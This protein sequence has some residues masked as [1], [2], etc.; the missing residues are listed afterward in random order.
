MV[1]LLAVYVSWVGWILAMSKQ[2][3]LTFAPGEILSV[4]AEAAEEGVW[5]ISGSTPTGVLLYLVWIVEALL[6]IGATAGVAMAIVSS[7]VFCEPCDRW[8]DTFETSPPL[9]V[10][11]SADVVGAL[12]NGDCQPVLDLSKADVSA[13]QFWHIE[14]TGCSTCDTSDLLSIKAVEKTF[15][16]KGK[17]QVNAKMVVEHLRIPRAVCEKIRQ[18][19]MT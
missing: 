10:P 16:K 9:A 7:A 8:L 13:R 19:H 4:I 14:L 18:Q 3:L 12:E 17:E 11:A 5:S 2:Q 15:D 6:I 1:G